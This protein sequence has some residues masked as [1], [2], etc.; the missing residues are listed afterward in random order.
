MQVYRSDDAHVGLPPFPTA[1]RRLR[2]EQFE[3]VET[4]VW[5]GDLERFA[6]YGA[7]FVLDEQQCAMG[8]PLG[9][10]LEQAEK[11][12]VGEEEARCVIR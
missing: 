12:Y 9:Y 11:I 1:V 5:L 10:F 7:A 8:F 6:Q 2:L 3:S 4:E